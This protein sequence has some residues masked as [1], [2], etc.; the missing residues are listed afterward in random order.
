MLNQYVQGILAKEVETNDIGEMVDLVDF[1]H[2]NLEFRES[3]ID[4][5]TP[6]GAVAEKWQD[7][8]ILF[9]PEKTFVVVFKRWLVLIE[10]QIHDWIQ[11]AIDLDK[12]S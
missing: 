9:S 1:Y 3:Y 8:L 5:V 10:T 7:L 6:K 12:V 11:R 4:L 2:R